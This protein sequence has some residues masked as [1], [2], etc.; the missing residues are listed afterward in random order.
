M[1]KENPENPLKGTTINEQLEM[2][3]NAEPQYEKMTD[4]QKIEALQNALDHARSDRD[5]YMNS[6][7]DSQRELKQVKREL[8]T[9]KARLAELTES[10][11]PAQTYAQPYADPPPKPPAPL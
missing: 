6:Y 3:E 8:T 5:S 1:S 4:A 11:E 10:A 2:V 9:I 7:F